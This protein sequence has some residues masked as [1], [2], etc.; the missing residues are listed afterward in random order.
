MNA[1]RI[2]LFLFLFLNL[3]VP[4]RGGNFWKDNGNDQH[5]MDLT[6]LQDNFDVPKIGTFREIPI[7]RF[8]SKRGCTYL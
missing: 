1:L 2:I 7:A 4:I 6:Y 8:F 5:S 3:K